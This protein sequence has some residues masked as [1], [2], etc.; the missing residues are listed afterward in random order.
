RY[1]PQ[2]SAH[3]YPHRHGA[4]ACCVGGLLYSR[5]PRHCRRSDG[6]APLRMILAP[7]AV[8]QSS[9]AV[10]E[11]RLLLNYLLSPKSCIAV[12]EYSSGR[13]RSLREIPRH[14]THHPDFFAASLRR[15]D[16]LRAGLGQ[17]YPGK[18]SAPPRVGYCEA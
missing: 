6:G 17:S 15:A 2:R 9:M 1:T 10:A 5:A 3:L 4:R 8:K 14:E 12:L 18:I 11:A 13:E 7:A 16:C